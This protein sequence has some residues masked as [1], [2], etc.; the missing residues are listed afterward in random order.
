MRFNKILVIIQ[1]SN[2]D[3]LL[4][5]SLIEQLQENFQP[6]EIDLLVN[7]DTVSVAK[8]LPN[9]HQIFTFSYQMK[10]ESRWRQEKAIF[11]KIFRKYDLSINLTASDRSVLYAIFA[12]K[13]SISAIEKNLKKSW[14]K[15]ILLNMHYSF[16]NQKHILLNNLTPLILL[17]LKPSRI[18]K[19]PH[20]S[21]KI[22]E[23][24]KHRLSELNISKFLI[25]HPSAQY[26]YKVYS[27]KLRNELFYLLSQS[28]IKIIITGGGSSID[29]DIKQILPA[30]ENIIDWIGETSIEEYIALSKLSFGYIGMDTLNMHIAAAQNKRVFA[31]F[32][33]TN[34]LMWSPWSNKLQVSASKNQPIQTYGNITIFQANMNCVACGM[35]GCNN[36]GKSECLKNI[37]PKLIFDEVS[38]W[39]KNAR[40]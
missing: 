1:R 14:W 25:F 24:I 36:S 17:G 13:N 7:D 19:A 21:E 22:I 27:E 16:D 8:T 3:V 32:G 40:L 37:S 39:Y 30:Y 31:I 11:K 28:N 35:A 20:T 33:P 6:K 5:S 34:L 23:S 26:E 2:G 4:S 18:V 38:N 15:R 9:I 12:S 29:K 10:H